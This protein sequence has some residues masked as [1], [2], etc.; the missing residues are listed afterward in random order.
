MR[1]TAEIYGFTP[2][3]HNYICYPFHGEKTASL[4]LYE[5]YFH[6]FGCGAHGDIINFVQ[7]LKNTG[8][9]E[10]AK[11]LADLTGISY[12]T[13]K[14]SAPVRNSPTRSELLRYYDAWEKSAFRTLNNYFK[15]LQQFY[16]D[17]KPCDSADKLHPLFVKSLHELEYVHSL[18][19]LFISG[20]AEERK[21]FY[22]SR[23]EVI[24]D[25]EL[26]YKRYTGT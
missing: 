24:H 21:K 14:K 19:M 12:S 1:E 20:S 9:L 7:R 10:A 6:C 18:C 8:A 15:L 16:N 17:F 22:I 2:D 13:H 23:K 25:F 3:R 4:R 26:Q 5:D 11:E